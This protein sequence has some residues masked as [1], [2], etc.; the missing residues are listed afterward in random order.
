MTRKPSDTP[1]KEGKPARSPVARVSRFVHVLLGRRR[2]GWTPRERELRDELGRLA[3]VLLGLFSA[4]LAIVVLAQPQVSLSTLVTLLAVAVASVSAQTV[5]AGGRLL[6]PEDVDGRGPGS[7]WTRWL[8]PWGVVG[9]GLLAVILAVFA[10]ADSNLAVKV[11]VFVLALA[12]VSQ[13]LGRIF[14]SN[15]V[16]L[17]LWLR[18]SSLGT[19]VLSVVLV[20]GSLA[21]YGVA[22]AAFAILVGVILLVGGIET[23]VAGLRPTD[24]RQFVLLKLILF[25]A[26]YGLILI[27][28]IDLFG[29]TVPGY[30]VWLI[31]TYMAPF[32]VLLVFEGWSSWPLATC[33]GLLVSLF[34]DVGYY[35]IGNLIFGFHVPLGPW[36]AGQLGFQG[37]AVVTYFEGGNFS[38]AVTSWMMGLS[39]YLRAIV[40]AA[41]LYYWWR[42]PG[43]IV[44]R[45]SSPPRAAAT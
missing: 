32:G 28:W 38:L 30:G 6:D 36:I 37:S 24:P 33:L 23:V 9:I 12:L 3:Q 31:L 39:I 18:G 10:A 43:E 13:G 44:A 21:F 19:G 17:P 42:H 20:V 15:G 27:N 11:V 40:V 35:F 26:F 14:H 5:L 2:R 4:G 22:I 1:K 45:I 8:V 29:K 16:T 41:I 25:A 7:R 34:N